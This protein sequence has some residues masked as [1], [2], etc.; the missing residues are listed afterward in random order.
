MSTARHTGYLRPAL[1]ALALLIIV[2]LLSVVLAVQWQPAVVRSVAVDS[3]AINTIEEL[4]VDNAPASVGQPGELSLHLDRDEL[5]LLAAFALQ[6]IPGMGAIAARVD[7]QQDLVLLDLSIPLLLPLRP[8]YLNVHAELLAVSG[9]AVP[10]TLWIGRLP[11]PG[12]AMRMLLSLGEQWLASTYVNYD[13]LRQ[14]KDSVSTISIDDHALQLT[15]LWEPQLIASV[16]SQAEQLLLSA[17]DTVRIDRYSERLVQVVEQLPD[18]TRS[19]SLSDLLTPLFQQAQ[20]DVA[21]GADP[22]AE[23]RW[24]LQALARYVNASANDATPATRRVAIT[25]QRRPDLAQHFTSSAAMTASVGADIAGLLA[26]SKEVHDARY[27]SGFSFSDLTANM[28]GVA[29]GNAATSN[30]ASARQLQ[31]R[32]AQVSVETDYMP[33]VARDNVGLSEDDFLQQFQDRTSPAYLERLSAI[34]E[35]LAALPIYAEQ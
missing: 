10:G 19:V 21:E 12:L 16:Q 22:V 13:T 33:Q 24:L 5:N 31:T 34:D 2:L 25:I 35:L 9:S 3:I 29:F 20:S 11:V 7:I 30:A 4:I 26:T 28:A 6:T 18:T 23:N 1:V 17:D 8:L 27:R 15:L 32:L 14:L